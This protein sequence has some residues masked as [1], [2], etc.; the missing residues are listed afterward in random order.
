MLA[1]KLAG[2]VIVN[3]TAT[4]AVSSVTRGRRGGALRP[5]PIIA[6]LS[7]KTRIFAFLVHRPEFKHGLVHCLHSTSLSSSQLLP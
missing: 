4:T 7:Q 5:A 6:D 2:H 1:N 3:R